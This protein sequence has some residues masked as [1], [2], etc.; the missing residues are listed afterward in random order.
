MMQPVPSDYVFFICSTLNSPY[1]G[2]PEASRFADTVECISSIK[3]AVPDARIL[4]VDNSSSFVDHHT[5]EMMRRLV[6]Q[7]VQL[8]HNLF[9]LNANEHKLKSASEANLMWTALNILLNP[10][11]GYT[12]CKRIFKISGRYKLNEDFDI[13]FYKDP[14]FNDKYAFVPMQFA[15]TYDNWKSQRRVMRLETGLVS[16]SPSLTKEFRD[17]MGSVMW[18][19][20]T[21]DNCIE[22][23]LF[24]H[25]P[26]EKIVPLTRVGVQGNKAETGELVKY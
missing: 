6:T 4:L 10:I 8:E 20:L 15:S 14:Q 3:A 21:N 13:N 18:Q 16:W 26:H 25:V 1:G 23:A 2:I 11:Y 12:N 5:P 19:C 17:M 9:S 24:N 22:E 7:Y